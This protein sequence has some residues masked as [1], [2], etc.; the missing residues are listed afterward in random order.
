MSD[1]VDARVLAARIVHAVVFDGRSLKAVLNESLPSMRDSR[2]RALVEAMVMAVI[3]N[4]VAY[5][6]TID[7]MM[8]RPLGKRDADLRALLY[9]G[10]AQLHDMGLAAH[11]SLATTV[12]AARAIG[13]A[14]QANMVNAVLRR[15]QR[16]GVLPLPSSSEWPPFLVEMVRRDWG[17]LA[18]MV[19][20]QS[21]LQAPMFLRVNPR[22]ISR[23]EYLAS[24]PMDAVAVPEFEH[25]IELSEAVSVHDLP[26]FAEG[27]VSVQDLSAQ[28]TAYLVNASG[29][30]LDAC[31]AP[32][33]KTAALLETQSPNKLIALDNNARRLKQIEETLQRL[34]L[35][36]PN[37]SLQVADSRTIRFDH[38]F[39][40]VVLDVP[41]SA[42]GVVRRQP[43][44]LLHRRR[45]DIDALVEMQHRI[46][47][48]GYAQLKPGGTLLYC[49][50]SILRVENANQIATFLGLHPDAEC[51]EIERTGY[52]IACTNDGKY[53]GHQRL[54]GDLH[55]DGFFYALI[56]KRA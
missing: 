11:A 34:K 30:V 1:G 46:L 28:A 13:R 36:G 52:G 25:A 2:D 22:F 40:T 7:R 24:L 4:R 26:G 23:D 12:D 16:E 47:L 54:P 9:I 15:V 37:V 21:A 32:G 29:D 43:D 19:F 10:I 38:S 41:C 50:C 27:H 49:T 5:Q 45:E 42:T 20:E 39:D 17:E 55:A 3:R 6:Q 31:A 8:P 33:G 18:D 48:N 44:V 35:L 14:H 53:V 51:V 56:R